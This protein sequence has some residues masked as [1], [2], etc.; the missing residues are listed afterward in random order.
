[1][2]GWRKAVCGTLITAFMLPQVII[3]SAGTA[4]AASGTWKHN[5]KGWWYSYSDG[6]YAKSAWVKDGGKW[7]YF[8]DKGYMVT[9]WKKINNKWYYFGNNGAMT[10]GWKK[11]DGKWYYFGTNGVMANNWKKIDGKW[12]YFVGGAMQTGWKKISG[13]WYYFNGSGV[14]TTGWKTISGKKY[15]FDENGVMATG[16]KTID[17]K[18]YTFGEDGVLAENPLAKAKVGDIITFG[19]YEQDNNLGN[20]KEAIEWIVLDKFSDGKMLVVSKFALDCKKYGETVNATWES[21]DLRKWLNEKFL[22]GSFSANEKAMIAKTLVRNDDNPKNGTD[23]GDDTEDY[24][25]LLSYEEV[26]KYYQNDTTVQGLDEIGQEYNYSVARSCKPTA[27]AEAEGANA[28]VWDEVYYPELKVFVG[29]CWWW[30]RTQGTKSNQ[31]MLVDD[32]GDPSW[33]SIINA[34]Y[35]GVRPALVIDP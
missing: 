25:F 11:I 24:V 6:T 9:S 15:Y 30:L 22:N 3:G 2:K 20:G 35:V 18:E 34:D 21:C 12:Y 31:A 4:E 19:E 29:C 33:S 17:G 13:A 14:M 27:Y 23:G 8:D 26:N 32:N 7:Y 16:T 28:F 1:M 10:T 5:S